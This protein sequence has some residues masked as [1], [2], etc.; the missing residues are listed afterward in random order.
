[1][2]ADVTYRPH[3]LRLPETCKDYAPVD[4]QGDVGWSPSWQAK[5]GAGHPVALLRVGGK[6]VDG[7]DKRGHDT[8]GGASAD[9][10]QGAGA[11]VAMTHGGAGRGS[12][13]PA[14]GR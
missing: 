2:N 7:R 10:T 6:D 14:V 3:P 9:M 11:S 1:M 13:V 5:A 4:K 12:I 8:G